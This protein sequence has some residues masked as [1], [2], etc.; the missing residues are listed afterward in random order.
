MQTQSRNLELAKTVYS[1]V[2]SQDYE[3]L[4]ELVSPAMKTYTGGK[5]LDL[6]AWLGMAK[7]F[8]TA[9]PDGR[10]V[11]E[12]A[13]AAGDYVLLNGYFTGTHTGDFMGIPATGKV[14]KC[15]LTMI[16]KVLDGKLVEHRSDFDTAAFMQQ[17]TQ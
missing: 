14:V 7:V 12:M 13:D 1:H 17:I 10:H 11:F 3:R 4:P 15:S 5:V 2:D 9:F 8:M 6:A 16:D